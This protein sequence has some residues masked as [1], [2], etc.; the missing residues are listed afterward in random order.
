MKFY[1]R[2]YNTLHLDDE[3]RWAVI[4]TPAM[5]LE[6]KDVFSDEKAYYFVIQWLVFSAMVIVTRKKKPIPEGEC[7]IRID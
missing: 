5:S 3:N 4:F 7:N 6:R 1:F 2:A